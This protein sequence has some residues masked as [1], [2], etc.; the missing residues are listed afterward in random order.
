M[1]ERIKAELYEGGGFEV[2]VHAKLAPP[3][4]GG[5]R[6]Q[7][8]GGPRSAETKAWLE[9]MD[10]ET[11]QRMLSRQGS[12]DTNA[13]F[14]HKAHGEGTVTRQDPDGKT[15]IEFDNGEVHRYAPE[16]LRKLH[17]CIE[18]P[19]DLTAQRLFEL[20]DTDSSGSLGLDE[21]EFL[22]ASIL[23]GER[24]AAA[25]VAETKQKAAAEV[26]EAERKE[27]ES[28]EAARKLRK[29]LF[30]AIVVI[31]LLLACIGGL[32]VV[33]VWAFKDT[34]LARGANDAAM[35]GA[36]GA[37]VTVGTVRTPVPLMVAPVMAAEQLRQ[38]DM[39][40]VS[41]ADK[42]TLGV[43]KK[44]E[45]IT[46]ASRIVKNATVVEFKSN[47]PGRS[48][49]VHNGVAYLEETVG[50]GTKY[51]HFLC[52]FDASCSSLLVEAAEEEALVEAA[53]TALVDAGFAVERRRML[54]GGDGCPVDVVRA[55]PR[56]TPPRP[57]LAAP[58]SSRALP[59]A[60][61]TSAPC[62]RTSAATS[63]P[64]SATRTITRP[65]MRS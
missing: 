15:V 17:P 46:I 58:L 27:S 6:S 41:Y 13:R 11:K 57:L 16:S 43:T 64:P 5:P 44:T 28:A 37:L 54:G 30:V 2:E 4:S 19:Q 59:R 60:A 38:V 33:V 63:P 48:V 45:V 56:P 31:V 29:Y 9:N 36:D 32:M 53:T 39:I 20:C 34:Y 35:V 50:D 26:A 55:R 1:D 7:V 61:S 12:I 21:F 24:K 47:V 25:A 52:T 49:F 51:R 40:T 8:S 23:K 42:A 18:N 22:H 65:A 14:F 62:S 10:A 3:V